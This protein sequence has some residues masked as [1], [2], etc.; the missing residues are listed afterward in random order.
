MHR[1][2]I[3]SLP[4]AALPVFWKEGGSSLQSAGA[5]PLII[6]VFFN[7]SAE[8]EILSSGKNVSRFYSVNF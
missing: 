5:K 2:L 4:W 3:R 7:S 6:Q 8:L 1:G